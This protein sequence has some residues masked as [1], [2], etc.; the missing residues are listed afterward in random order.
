MLKPASVAW[1]AGITSLTMVL[2]AAATTAD[3]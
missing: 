3:G 1:K 2:K